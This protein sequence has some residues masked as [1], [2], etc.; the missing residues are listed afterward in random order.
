[1]SR[2]HVGEEV[3]YDGEVFVIAGRNGEEVPR[4]RLLASRPEGT[5]FVIAHEE[6]LEKIASYLTARDDTDNY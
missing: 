2:F 3:R 1:M 5:R 6:E 4:Y